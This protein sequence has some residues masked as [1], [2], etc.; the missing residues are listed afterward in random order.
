[1]TAASM[2]L[3]SLDWLARHA[4][5]L[6]AGGLFVGIVSP[7]LA[8]LFRPV[9]GP[10]VFVL[11]VATVLRIDWDRAAAYVRRPAR[12]RR[13]GRVVAARRAAD[14][15]DRN[16]GG[17]ACPTAFRARSCSRLARRC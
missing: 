1:M 6:I 11:M 7:D 17:V 16:A 4:S 9:V 2:I 14:R 13:R 8:R 15:V 12:R 10:S 3:K 5:W